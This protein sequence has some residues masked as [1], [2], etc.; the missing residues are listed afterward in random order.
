MILPL[1]K[2]PTDLIPSKDSPASRAGVRF[3][4][5]ADADSASPSASNPI[6]RLMGKNLMVANKEDNARIYPC[7]MGR[8][9][10]VLTMS[11]K[12]ILTFQHLCSLSWQLIFGIRTVIHFITWPLK[13]LSSSMQD[14]GST[15]GCW[16]LR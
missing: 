7:Q 10:L 12:L 5:R 2:P 16:V 1:I 9:N 13:V 4:A 3:L 15:F 11:I 6:L 8:S 14:S